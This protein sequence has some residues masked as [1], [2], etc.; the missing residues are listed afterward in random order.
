MTTGTTVLMPGERFLAEAIHRYGI[1]HVFFV[2]YIATPSLAALEALG[3]R[4]VST[5]SELAAAYMADGYA[6]A[7]GRPG[8]CFAQ[9]VG[10]INLAAGLRDA[11]LAGSPVIAITGGPHPDSRYRHLYQQ[12]EDLAMFDPVTK[13]NARVDKPERLPDLLLQ[14][15]RAATAGAPGPVHLELPGRA[16]EG[17][18]G[19][20]LDLTIEERFSRYPAYRTAPEP[21]AVRAAA[22]ALAAARRPVIVAGGGVVAS[23]AAREL[24]EL[25]ERFAIPVATSLNGK[26]TIPDDHPLC[27][28]LVGSYGRWCANEVVAAADMVFFIGSRAGGM[29]TDH[30][31]APPPGT[32]VIQLD[33]DPVE[34][35]RNYPV[36]VGL[37]GDA[38]VTLRHLLAMLE[39]PPD[40]REWLAHAQAQV[41]AWRAAIEPMAT[42]DAVPI[43]P[44]RLCHELSAWL[45]PDG[46]IVA[47]TGHIAQW[48][49]TLLGLRQ[50]G[51]R[52]IRCAGTLGWGL[53]GAIGVKRALP[54]RPVVCV[55]G[56]GGLYY[57][58]S[59]LETAARL[60]INVVVVVN[61]NAGLSQTKPGYDAAHGGGPYRT[62]ETWQYRPT[63]F[64]A[65]AEALG[66][67]GLRVERPAELRGALAHAVAAGRPAVIDVI[68]DVAALPFRPWR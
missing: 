63:D 47:D 23:G 60:G 55:T 49:G 8:I 62:H 16:G 19:G 15:F 27:L 48:T 42:S 56:D 64:A 13:F 32:P 57:H 28:G 12:I 38:Q 22:V 2:P 33:I 24:V 9:A 6:R 7:A 21:E 40:R 36:M 43:R 11:F 29:V 3:V 65:V 61:D 54:D 35:G 44:E 53:P 20:A 52:F 5:H 1:T 34:I 17:I 14:A 45:P 51:Q 68:T 67:L 26:E 66:C 18:Q 39:P 59:E 4:R 31:Q 37:A 46:V 30:W 25:A 58:L 41:H 50:P 10:A